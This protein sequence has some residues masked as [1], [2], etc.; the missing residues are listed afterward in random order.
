[1]CTDSRVLQRDGAQTRRKTALCAK[2]FCTC[3]DGSFAEGECAS[4]QKCAATISGAKTDGAKMAIV[5]KCPFHRH[6]F[7][8][9]SFEQKAASNKRYL[10]VERRAQALFASTKGDVR[11]SYAQD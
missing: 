2:F 11:G 6:F 4:K 5:K 3:E 9:I 7:Y 8:V 1:V 10:C